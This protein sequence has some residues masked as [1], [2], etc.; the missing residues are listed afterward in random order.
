MSDNIYPRA[1]IFG[2]GDEQDGKEAVGKFRRF[3]QGRTKMGDP[4]PICI[5]EI[6]AEERAVW[7]NAMALRNKFADEVGKREGKNLDPGEIVSVVRGEKRQSQSSP[8]RSYW[9]FTVGFEHAAQL[10][11]LEILSAGVPLGA[12]APPP[13]AGVE[14]DIPF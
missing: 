2:E 9:T 3:A 7:L 14:D 5:L 13:P 8:D 10:S 12:T 6:D 4:V 11:A 1:W